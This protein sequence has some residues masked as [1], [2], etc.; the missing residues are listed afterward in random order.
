M[1]WFWLWAKFAFFYFGVRLKNKKCDLEK[2]HKTRIYKENTIVIRTLG[3]RISMVYSYGCG[4]GIWTSRPSGYEPDELPDCSIPRYYGAGSRGRTGTR[5]KSHGILSP[6][7]LPIPPFR[8]T[9]DLCLPQRLIIITP[10]SRKVNT[11]WKNR[12]LNID[13]PKKMC[14]YIWALVINITHLA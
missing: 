3:V 4:S 6:G 2:P 7:R 12:Y 1:F 9:N 14:Y 13:K 10:K 5:N 11:F 8:Q